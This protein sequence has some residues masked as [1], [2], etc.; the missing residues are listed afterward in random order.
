MKPRT[1]D[2]KRQADLYKR[3]VTMQYLKRYR[4]Y[5][6][7][8][9]HQENWEV[10]INEVMYSGDIHLLNDRAIVICIMF[11][12]NLSHFLLDNHLRGFICAY[13]MENYNHI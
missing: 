13:S 6:Y 9:Q 7:L 11:R 2:I 10:M 12:D 8:Y 1:M 4:L 5:V 3:M